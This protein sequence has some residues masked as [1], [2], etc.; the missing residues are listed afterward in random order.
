MVW[1]VGQPRKWSRISSLYENHVEPL[2]SASMVSY[3]SGACSRTQTQGSMRIS[4]SAAAIQRST[5]SIH[6]TSAACSGGTATAPASHADTSSALACTSSASCSR[7]QPRRSRSA[8]TCSADATS[9]RGARSLKRM[10]NS[11]EDRR[12]A[13][14]RARANTADHGTSFRSPARSGPDG[15]QCSYRPASTTPRMASMSPPCTPMASMSS[16][17]ACWPVMWSAKMAPISRS[18]WPPPG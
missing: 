5:D 3:R 15:P 4:A 6:S 17:R 11:G 10:M 7:V 16:M 9:L 12:M 14:R 13:V 2:T 18:T 1:Q 8:R